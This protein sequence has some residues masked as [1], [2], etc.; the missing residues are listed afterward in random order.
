MLLADQFSTT[1]TEALTSGGATA[2][3]LPMVSARAAVSVLPIRLCRAKRDRPP[4][5]PARASDLD[6]VKLSG[7]RPRAVKDPARRPFTRVAVG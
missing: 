1:V 7:Y 2:D 6:V 4:A 5:H 3:I